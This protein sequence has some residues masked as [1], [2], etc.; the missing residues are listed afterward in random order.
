MKTWLKG[1]LWGILIILLTIQLTLAQDIKTKPMGEVYIFYI[2]WI[3]LFIISA[4]IY[5]YLLFKN[6]IMTN[7]SYWLKGGLSALVLNFLFW[8]EGLLSMIILLNV[9]G[10]GGFA[11]LII[12]WGFLFSILPSFIIGA[13][14]GLIYDKIKSKKQRK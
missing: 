5:L 10:E 14:I 12:L 11:G 4:I 9:G 2:I 6:K 8:V 3:F 1:G 7:L 13:I